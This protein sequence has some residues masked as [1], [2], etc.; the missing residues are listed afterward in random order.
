MSIRALDFCS[1]SDDQISSIVDGKSGA[2]FFVFPLDP[3]SS[4]PASS[5][6]PSPGSSTHFGFKTVPEDQKESLVRGVFSSVASKYDVMNDAMSLGIHRLWK[7]HYVA[8]MDPHGG[9]RCLDVAG[10]TGDIAI[11]LLDHARTKWA[12]RDTHV[13]V[14]DINPEMLE[15]GKK[16]FAQTMYH[17]G[18]Q[19]SFTL[20]N[21]ENLEDVPDNS[22]DLYTIAFGIRNCTHVDQVLREAY[23]VIKPGGV[24][25]CLEFSKV[26]NPLVAKAYNLYSFQVIPNIGHIVAAD[27]DSYQYLVESIERFPP[28]AKFSRMIEEAGFTVPKQEPWEDLT[29]GVAAIHTGVKV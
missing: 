13:Q 25:S 22:V 7:D 1:S 23:R 29:F 24:F 12:D 8:K 16:R 11:R 2:F 14:L 9:I 6:G 5:S 19:V 21:A 26:T 18:P 17:G 10:G 27:R 28:Q 20:G 3:P 4:S 15:E